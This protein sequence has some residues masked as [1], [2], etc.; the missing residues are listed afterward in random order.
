MSPTVKIL[1]F[2]IHILTTS[3]IKNSGEKTNPLE[4]LFG[5]LYTGYRYPAGFQLR[6]D[7]GYPAGFYSYIFNAL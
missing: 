2:Q 3:I 4:K 7:T 6:P 5:K 1:T